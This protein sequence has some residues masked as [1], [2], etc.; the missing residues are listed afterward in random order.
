VK[1]LQNAVTSVAD[2]IATLLN[3]L[4][5]YFA[6]PGGGL[7][8]CN[9]YV[10]LSVCL[11]AHITGKTTRPIFT[12]FLLHAACGHGSVLL[13]QRCDRLCISGFVNNVV[14]SQHGTISQ[15]QA[16]RHISQPAFNRVHQNATPGAK[17][18]IYDFLVY[19]LS[20]SQYSASCSMQL[21][22]DERVYTSV[23]CVC[24]SV[25]PQAYLKN[26]ASILHQLQLSHVF[27]VSWMASHFHAMDPTAAW[28]YHSSVSIMVLQCGIGY[29]LS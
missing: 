15:N 29:V 1:R 9:E 7:K 5:Y 23:W 27:P 11:S 24:L 3:L 6:P 26:H 19:L 18:G 17:S 21:Y 14:F 10:S 16:W 25:C 28:R 8:Y 20:S 4:C 2:V 12:K 22:C 13:W